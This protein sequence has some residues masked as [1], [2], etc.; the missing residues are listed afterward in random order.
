MSDPRSPYRV[1]IVR[2]W[3]EA[4]HE[5]ALRIRVIEAAG[6]HRPEQDLLTTSSSATACDTVCAWLAA[7]ADPPR[8]GTGGS[9]QGG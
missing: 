3:Y 9:P 2:A 8:S 6:A 7:L 4:G 5:Q 1:L